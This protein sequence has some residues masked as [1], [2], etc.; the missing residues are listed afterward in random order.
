VLPSLR[1]FSEETGMR[2]RLFFLRHEDGRR[3][4][5]LHVVPDAALATSN[6]I[7]LRNLLRC[8][9]GHARRY[10]E[11]KRSLAASFPEDG[12]AYTRGKTDLIQE[13]VNEARE[14]AGLAP[15][16]VWED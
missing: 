8:H 14:A 13:F 7:L 12:L 9:P 5:P 16:P 11:L 10:A 6:E 2:G 15:V 1:F 4:C 3:V